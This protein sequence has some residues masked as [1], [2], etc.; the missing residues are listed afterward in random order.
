MSESP[1]RVDMTVALRHLEHAPLPGS[2]A[3]SIDDIPR[4][5][6]LMLDAYRGTIDFEEET[7]EQS[8]A[9]INR[10]FAGEYGP[11]M[12]ECSRIVERDGRLVCAVL[13]TRWQDRPFIA[14][15]MT[16][17][18]AKRQGLARACM[19]DAMQAVH[20][21]GDDKLSLVVTIANLAAHDLYESLGF[22]RGR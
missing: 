12:P 13:L 15:A 6:A 4:L 20:E 11:F 17:A 1:R 9:E 14:Y 3:P 18:D 16:A 5:G 22:V 8:I 7:L 19:L 10:T 21:S 2:R